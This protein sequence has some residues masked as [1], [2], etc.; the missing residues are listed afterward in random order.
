MSAIEKMS[1]DLL[2]FENCYVLSLKKESAIENN[3]RRHIVFRKLFHVK[4]QENV[5]R[6]KCPS[7]A[8][9]S[10]DII[11]NGGHFLE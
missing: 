5:R 10:A 1:A 7:K 8:N 9:M 3:V 4:T 6:D 11:F 2:A